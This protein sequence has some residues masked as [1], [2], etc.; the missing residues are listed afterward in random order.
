MAP[1]RP[2]ASK[3]PPPPSACTSISYDWACPPPAAMC[4]SPSTQNTLA[5]RVFEGLPPATAFTQHCR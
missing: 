3:S 1:T 2:I 4:P 5:N